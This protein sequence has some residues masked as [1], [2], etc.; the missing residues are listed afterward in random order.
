MIAQLGTFPVGHRVLR[1][2]TLDHLTAI[3]FRLIGE[4]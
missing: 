3:M 2:N 4:P 1:R